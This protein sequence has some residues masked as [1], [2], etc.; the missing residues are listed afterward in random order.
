MKIDISHLLR[1]K[2]I[3]KFILCKHSRPKKS[4]IESHLTYGQ[5]FPNRSFQE[6]KI[7]KSCEINFI[8]NETNILRMKRYISVIYFEFKRYN[9]YLR[10]NILK[11]QKM[12][13]FKEIIQEKSW[14]GIQFF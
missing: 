5:P 2:N 3:L 13:I 11:I 8:F 14:D 6:K 4:S 1:S 12:P 7:R 10:K 9:L